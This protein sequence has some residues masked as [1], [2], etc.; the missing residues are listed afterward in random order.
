MARRR[1]ISEVADR[2]SVEPEIARGLVNFLV[3]A[4]V[5]HN[6]GK[7]GAIRGPSENVYEFEDNYESMVELFLRVGKL[8]ED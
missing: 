2:F 7:R 5:V 4:K 3:A 6:V 1:T 8:S